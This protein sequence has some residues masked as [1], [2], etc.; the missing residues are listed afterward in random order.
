MRP[1][2]N[3][4]S[5]R[6]HWTATSMSVLSDQEGFVVTR[7]P[8]YDVVDTTTGKTAAYTDKAVVSSAGPATLRHTVNKAIWPGEMSPSSWWMTW[9]ISAGQYVHLA[10][11][12]STGAKNTWDWRVAA[13]KAQSTTMPRTLNL[14]RAPPGFQVVDE[15][16]EFSPGESGVSPLITLCPNGFVDASAGRADPARHGCIQVGAYRAGQDPFGRIP[17]SQFASSVVNGRRLRVDAP[18]G[19]AVQ[20]QANGSIVVVADP[21][22]GLTESDLAGI[23]ASAT[24]DPKF[25]ASRGGSGPP[26]MNSISGGDV[27]PPITE[28][29]QQ[30]ELPVMPSVI[31][32]DLHIASWSVGVDQFDVTYKGAASGRMAWIG[33]QEPVF[34]IPA[35]GIGSG[36]G[37]APASGAASVPTNPWH[38]TP[39]TMPGGRVVFVAISSGTQQELDQMAAGIQDK[40][41][42]LSS[43]I[44]VQQGVAGYGS[45]FGGGTG[46]I[47]G[48]NEWISMCPAGVAANDEVVFEVP[49]SRRCVSIQLTR[50]QDYGGNRNSSFGGSPPGSVIGIT[51][52]GG[53]MMFAVVDVD[54][55]LALVHL[56]KG[57][58]LTLALPSLGGVSDVTQYLSILGTAK[59]AGS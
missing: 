55:T 52:P 18:D 29:R 13:V 33:S 57:R 22:I 56:D 9:P 40:P 45:L 31:P 58:W 14:L 50:H 25:L 49:Q 7:S 4:S 19:R 46:Q 16:D 35:G 44:D 38:T 42:A 41:F 32:A 1:V 34:A 5:V 28:S 24:V 27:S 3:L 37:N 20:L 39:V 10:L 2:S 54:R 11:S 21:S 8:N 6:W 53:P 26:P 15:S 47:P 30:V 48:G 51:R 12:Y 36:T 23:A 59:L 43:V 17:Q